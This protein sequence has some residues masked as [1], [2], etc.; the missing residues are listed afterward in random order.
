MKRLQ[1]VSMLLTCTKN[2]IG[3]IFCPRYLIVIAYAFEI[4]TEIL[5]GAAYDAIHYR[6][7]SRIN[8]IHRIC[9]HFVHSRHFQEGN[10][11]NNI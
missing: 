3:I 11:D 5:L 9:K 8:P 1:I 7:C 4:V 10:C 6:K 2:A